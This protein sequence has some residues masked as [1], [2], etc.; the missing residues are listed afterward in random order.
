M[1]LGL[2]TAAL[3]DLSLEAC[4]D[5]AAASGFGMIEIACWLRAEWSLE[6]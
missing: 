5:W 3:P 4:A 2:L 1:K 6:R